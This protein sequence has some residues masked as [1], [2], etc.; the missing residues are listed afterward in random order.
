MKLNIHPQLRWQITQRGVR[1]FL[2][3]ETVFLEY[4]QAAIWDFISRGY[5]L[6]KTKQLLQHI[7]ALD[8]DD[9]DKLVT[10]AVQSWLTNKYIEEITN[11]G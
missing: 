2:N 4:P 7:A 11:R 5:Q 9:T 8:V 6:D 10:E 1:L 3:S